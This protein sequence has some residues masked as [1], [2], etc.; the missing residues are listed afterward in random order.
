MMIVYIYMY[1]LFIY[2]YIIPK[3]N[4]IIV[5]V[6]ILGNPLLFPSWTKYDDDNVHLNKLK[7]FV[8]IHKYTY[9]YT[10]KYTYIVI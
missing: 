6:C 2:I 3:A 5:K 1:Y 7:P 8:Y 10:Y 9:I 4:P